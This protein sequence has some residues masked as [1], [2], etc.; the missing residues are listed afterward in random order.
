MYGSEI[1]HSL[2]ENRISLKWNGDRDSLNVSYRVLPYNFSDYQSILDEK[3]VDKKGSLIRIESDYS[4]DELEQRR[5]IRSNKLEYSGSFSRGI[6]FGNTQ[7]LVLNSDFNLQMEGDLGNGLFV[8]AAIS[9]DNIPIQPEGNTQV[10]QEFDKVFIE[11]EKDNTTVIAG[12]YELAKPQSYFMNY[13]KKLKGLSLL[14]TKES[15]GGWKLKNRGSFAIS[16]GKFKRINLATQEGNQGPYK[17]EGEEGDIY[18]QVLS[19]TE[20]VYADGLLLQRG[21]NNA[22]VIDYNRAE[23]R[24]TPKMI[25]TANT[26][27]IVEYEFA[28]Q[29]YVRSL[30]ATESTIENDKWRFDLNI[31]NEQDSKNLAS[32]IT[33]DSTDLSLLENGG[34]AGIFRSG[35]FRPEENNF[36][37]IIPYLYQGDSLEYAPN[38]DPDLTPNLV[39]AQFS[40]LGSNIGSY[41]I[42]QTAA[43]NGRVYRYVGENQGSYDPVVQLIAPEKKQLITTAAS[44]KPRDSTTLSLET[45]LSQN[46]LN[47][48]SAINNEDNLGLSFYGAFSDIRSFNKKLSGLDSL[49]KN[50]AW[51]LNSEGSFEIKQKN[52]KALNPYR[53]PEFSRDWNY[54]NDTIKTDEYLYKFNVNLSKNG[55]GLGYGFSGLNVPDNYDGLQQNLSLAYLKSGWQI[56]G[57]GNLLISE[58]LN[59]NTKF[60][61][62]NFRIKKTIYKSWALGVRYEKE[63]NI[64]RENGTEFIKDNSL[65]FDLY[66]AF[67][68]SDLN[69]NLFVNAS[70]TKRFDDLVKDQELQRATESIDYALGGGW[71]ASN[72]SDLRWNMTLRDYQVEANFEDDFDNKK[73][74]IGILDHKLKLFNSGLTLNS[75]LESDSGQEPKIEFQFVQVERGEGN[76]FWQESND[77]GEMQSYEF[78][79]DPTPEDA[80][81]IKVNVFNNEFI[82]T[83]KTV[84]NQSLRLNPKKILTNKS[85]WLGRFQATSRYRIDQRSLSSEGSQLFKPINLNPDSLISFSSSSDHN[86]FFNRGS[87]KYDLQIAYRSLAN[88]IQQVSGKERRTSN[89][90]YTRSRINLFKSLDFLVE[91]SLGRKE[92]ELKINSNQDFNLDFYKI[93]P[94]LNYR[95]STK[96]RLV[97]KYKHEKGENKINDFDKALINDIGFECTWRKSIKSSFQ[98]RTN[99]VMISYEGRENTPIELELIQGLKDGT[100]YVW[101]LNY[102]RRIGKNFDLILNYNARK[103]EGARLVNNAGAQLRANF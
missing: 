42:D 53:R 7:D 8:R 102:T 30:Y 2:T 12:D 20:K 57:R 41:I 31:Y 103:S 78:Q 15:Q 56:E 36:D 44:F 64:R 33:L 59:E 69:Q 27:I 3:K 32:N 61:R 19:G 89:E 50:D 71:L 45:G 101:M 47:R 58:G 48:F 73:T 23:L 62:P 13:Y 68:T 90:Y 65:N 91:T 38:L 18:L 10:L 26:R 28:T 83:N 37:N 35:L 24:F 98:L 16:R 21:E 25:I 74:L 96:L 46:D 34:D 93:T 55:L 22:Y 84:L 86:L 81:F 75:Y 52:F 54:Q 17:L 4:K 77:D 99:L 94:Q 76:Y 51:I 40:N 63:Q 92:Y 70:I 88:Q 72:K 6:N 60:F 14:N 49:S 67:I 29:S 11:I 39:G 1:P 9:D 82:S 85:H 5:F 95:P 87:T 79:L 43:T 97:A 80:D 66:S 100:N